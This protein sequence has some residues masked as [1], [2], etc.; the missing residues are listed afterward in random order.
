[1]M[2]ALPLALSAWLLYGGG[3]AA[4]VASTEFALTRAGTMEGNPI[5]RNRAARLALK[6]AQTSVLVWGDG[7]MGKK[8]RIVFRIGYALW[9][10]W[11]VQHNMRVTGGADGRPR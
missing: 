1:M 8:G 11:V 10:G 9:M 2:P 3:S 4:D 5:A 6:G 7:K